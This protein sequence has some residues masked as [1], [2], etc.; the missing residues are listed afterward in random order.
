[1]SPALSGHP[2]LGDS[3]SALQWAPCHV[4]NVVKRTQLL[5]PKAVSP[6]LTNNRLKTI[7]YQSPPCKGVCIRG[8]LQVW[9][10]TSGISTSWEVVRNADAQG[11]T[12]AS[13]VGSPAVE[14][15]TLPVVFQIPVLQVSPVPSPAREHTEV[16]KRVWRGP[17]VCSKSPR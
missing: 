11:P 2:Q 15:R 4:L 1:M 13:Q 3:P 16:Y 12:Q 8:S 17:G 14:P 6:L 10:L 7:N 9:S 5:F